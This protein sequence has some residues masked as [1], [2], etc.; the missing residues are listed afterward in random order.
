MEEDWKDFISYLASEKGLAVNSL[1]AYQRD[2]KKFCQFLVEKQ[3][4]SFKVVLENHI[5]EFLATLRAKH[6]ASSTIARHLITLKVL[7]R[8]LKREG[9]I[10]I[11]VTL[12][13]ETPHLWQIIPEVLS[14][15]EMDQLLQQPDIS[16]EIGARNKA[17]LEVLYASGLR[18]SELCQ[19]VINDVDDQFVRV[20]GKGNKE[21]LVPIGM[22]AVEAIDYYLAQYRDKYAD[23]RQQ[24]LFLT[25]RGQPLSRLAIWKT[26]KD[27]AKTMGIKKNIS[28]HS[29]RHSFATH[30]LDNGADLRI[31]QEM[32]GHATIG[33][34]ARY[35]QVSNQQLVIAFNQFH[36][37]NIV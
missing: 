7:F 20:K 8:F 28:P 12:Y 3:I 21:R 10:P 23:Q 25:K 16:T 26:I 22:K 33:S 19:L 14:H 2:G 1:E 37:R 32:L 4:G 27:Y 34:T 9:L 30:L 11:N 6:Y 15:E 13:L 36:P 35:T 18:V 24:T 29:L 5:I 31:I 17:I